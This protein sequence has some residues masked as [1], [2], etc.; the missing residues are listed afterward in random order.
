[1]KRIDKITWTCRYNVAIQTVTIVT[2]DKEENVLKMELQQTKNYNLSSVSSPWLLLVL[3]RKHWFRKIRNWLRKT[4]F[5][6]WMLLI[7]FEIMLNFAQISRFKFTGCLFYYTA[8]P[9]ALVPT[10]FHFSNPGRILRFSYSLLFSC[11][12]DPS[13]PFSNTTGHTYNDCATFVLIRE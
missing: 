9:S 10:T 2:V 4:S 11:I 6:L 5:N 7:S 13:V 8:N 3:M 12:W 1:M